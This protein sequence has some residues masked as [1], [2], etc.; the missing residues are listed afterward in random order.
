M[1][2][3]EFIGEYC[4]KRIHIVQVSK[5]TAKK[6]HETGE[7]ILMQTS[8]FHPFGV[9]SQAIEL[10]TDENNNSFEDVVCNFRFYNCSYEAGYY[11]TFYKVIV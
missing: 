3:L 7:R 9:W 11:V 1:R 10:R 6:L 5:V 4:G 8:N 2:N